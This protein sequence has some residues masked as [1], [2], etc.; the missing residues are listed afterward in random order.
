MKLQRIKLAEHRYSWLVLDDRY[1]PIKPIQEFI[2][3]LE[4]VERSPNT[5]QAYANHLKLYWEYLL[6]IGKDWNQVKLDD[7]AAF[8]GWLRQPHPNVISLIPEEA[9]RLESTVNTI[10]AAVS[11]FYNFN[12]QLG[13]T[14]IVLIKTS[15]STSRRYK[16]LLHH[17]TKSKPIKTRLVKLKQPK[18]FV[19]TL[20]TDQVKEILEACCS[21][22]DQFLISLL[23]EGGL[24]IGQAL[25]LRHCDIKSWDNEIH[26]HPRPYNENQ[27]RTKSI[28]ANVIH[29]SP[30][31]MTLYTR[32]LLD[33]VDVI[34]SDYVFIQTSQHHTQG[35]PLNYRAIRDLFARIAK[36]VGYRVSPH[37]LRHTHATELLRNGWDASY[38]QRRLGHRSIQTT[39]N[40][41]ANLSNSDLKKAFQE[42]KKGEKA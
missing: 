4:N 42:Y 41:Y 36:K 33:E 24:R 1:L 19:K 10:L 12:Q 32:Y 3:Y 27:A 23:Y 14:E 11:S 15:T 40:T 38:V 29:V 6:F 31:L 25:G 21:V 35:K 5:I 34:D 7:F 2:R 17:I 28:I 20:T 18:T 22:R 13:N 16:P 8:I 39:I 9:R 37:M 26:I 30:N